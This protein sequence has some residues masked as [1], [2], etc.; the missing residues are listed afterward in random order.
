[1]KTNTKLIA[2]AKNEA[3]YLP[4]WIYHHFSIGFDEIEIYINDT[5]DNSVAI[6]DKIK[7]NYANLTFHLAD[8]LRLESIKEK[9]SFQISAYN[10]SLHHSSETTHLMALDLDEYLICKNMD[11]RL[12]TLL[13]RQS[14]PDCLSF[15]W[16]SDDHS[17]KKSFSHPLQTHNTIFRM[18]H[19][20]TI[21]KLSRKV[22]ACSHHNFIYKNEERVINLLGGT[23]IRLDDNINTESRRSKLSKQQLNALSAEN[24]EPWFVLHCIYKSEEEYLA[25]LCRGRGH[26]N[27]QRPLKVNRW[28]MSS[29]PYYAKEP[30]HWHPS[31]E[32]IS[33]YKIGLDNFIQKND[34]EEELCIAKNSIKEATNY[35]DELLREQPHLRTDYK[36]IFA[37]TKYA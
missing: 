3:A 35:L 24:T 7:K 6:C 2:I 28:G 15:L 31:K 12:S 14:S 33:Q 18:D 36:K 21:S 19:V 4:Q 37:G 13:E 23:I 16:Y 5:T 1:M 10:N 8:K 9:R 27:D 11:E 29:Y 30:I 34:L 20:K 26:N 25:S 17:S 32:K 22:Q